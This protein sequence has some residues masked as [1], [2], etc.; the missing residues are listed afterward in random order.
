VTIRHRSTFPVST[1]IHVPTKPMGE[2]A[3]VDFRRARA[4]PCR[5][6]FVCECISRAFRNSIRSV[7]ASAGLVT[8]PRTL[9]SSNSRKR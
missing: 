1:F 3:I 7:P 8:L 4:S 9:P 6:R 2:A 5:K